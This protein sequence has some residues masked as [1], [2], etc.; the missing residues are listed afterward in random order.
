MRKHEQTIVA[1][2]NVCHLKVH[3]LT[4][5]TN[6]SLG[7]AVKKIKAKQVINNKIDDLNWIK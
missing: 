2:C 1:L 7:S 3:T 6:N 4:E 5:R